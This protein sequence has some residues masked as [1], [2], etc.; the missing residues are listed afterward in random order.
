MN[1][2]ATKPRMP[3]R[4]DPALWITWY[5][6]PDAG[7]DAYLEWLHGIYLPRLLERPGYLWAAHYAS[8]AQPKRN[9]KRGGASR[10]HPPAGSVPEGFRFILMIGGEHAHTFAQPTPRE[11][12]AALPENE[13]AMLAM[14][15]GVSSNIMIEQA[16]V[17]GPEAASRASGAA[18]SPCI[19]LGSFVFDGD[20]EDLYAWYAQWRL[21]SMTAI[22]GC[23]AV[24]KL[25][26]AAGWAKHAIL[27]EFTSARDRNEHFVNHEPRLHPDKVEWSDRITGQV[28]HAPGSP[29][30]AER[31]WSDS[32][33]R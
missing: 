23:V 16:R 15:A 32:R 20:E 18:T 28:I 2:D 22:P 6:L 19:Q 4:V 14:R 33:V 24:R 21:P 3:C 12:H 25:V 13:R 31:I 7:R 29:N 11:L 27:H 26:S 17:E 5:D 10:R 1:D 8:E 30:V 9:A